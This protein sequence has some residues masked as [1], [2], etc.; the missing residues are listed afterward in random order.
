MPVNFTHQ[1]E[2]AGAW[3]V[4]FYFHSIDN[5]QGL[6]NKSE[7]LSTKLMHVSHIKNG[8]EMLDLNDN[9]ITKVGEMFSH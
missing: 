8:F 4:K 1:G 3:R 7:T 5:C 2:S 9:D 6:K